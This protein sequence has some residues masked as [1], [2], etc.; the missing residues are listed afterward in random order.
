VA[1]R[2][3]L[4]AVSRS[5]FYAAGPA[6]S[7]GIQAKLTVGSA[8][9]PLEHEADAVADS[10]VGGRTAPAI[11]ALSSSS[12]QQAPVQRA[13]QEAPGP[14]LE[15]ELSPDEVSNDPQLVQSAPALQEAP[16]A[17]QEEELPLQRAPQ[18]VPVAEPDEELPV[19][20]CSC[21]GACTCGAAKTKDGA[22]TEPTHVQ[23]LAISS[24]TSTP[25]GTTSVARAV[26]SPGVG[27]PLQPG[28]RASI[29]RGT[30]HAMSAVRVHDDAAS[31]DAA[32][33]LRARAFTHGS[34]IWLGRSESPADL[35]L[36]SHE[37]TH[38]VQ[39]ADRPA[40]RVGPGR[41]PGA[42]LIQRSAA[43]SS[44]GGVPR[45]LLYL[46]FDNTL[47]VHFLTLDADVGAAFDADPDLAQR[48]DTE[49]TRIFNPAQRPLH[50][51]DGYM[52][53][54]AVGQLI[55][56]GLRALV[57]T[58]NYDFSALEQLLQQR[59]ALFYE[60][61]LLVPASSYLAG[62]LGVA[63][64]AIDWNMLI[65]LL[66]ARAN[67]SEVRTLYEAA[68]RDRYVLFLDMLAS[69]AAALAPVVGAASISA[70]QADAQL[71]TY[72]QDNG[73]G[74]F[75][76]AVFG[77]HS[78]KF[79]D[80]YVPLLE[81]LRYT[82]ATFDL[83]TFRPA[84]DT[85]RLDASREQ[86]VTNFIE[87][88][89]HG[90]VIQFTLDRWTESGQSPEEFLADLD[91]EEFRTELTAQLANELVERARA[92]PELMAALRSR[93]LDQA[94]FVQ[95]S[96]LYFYA[97]GL[98]SYNQGLGATFADTPLDAVSV[99]DAAIAADPYAYYNLSSTIAD[100]L[101]NLLASI[102]PNSPI[103]AA[104]V[105][106]GAT[107]LADQN[108]PTQ[109]AGLFLL[110]ELLAYFNA[111]AKGIEEQERATQE[112]LKD[113]LDLDFAAIADTVRRWSDY[114]D[115][116]IEEVWKPMLKLVALE[117]LAANREEI[118][119]IYDDLDD[120]DAEFILRLNEGADELERLAQRLEAGDYASLELEGQTVTIDDVAELRTA[121]QFLRD[122]AGARS[123]PERIEAQRE[124]LGEALDVYET[125]R[126]DI[127]DDEYDPLD[128]S[129]P[130]YEEARRRLGI[131]EF[132]EFTTVG[133]VLRGDVAATRNPFLAQA[134]VGWHWREGVER[135]IETGLLL[136]GLL[137]LTAGAMLVPG[138]GGAVL[139]ALD[140]GIGIGMGV[141]QIADAN[142]V[143]NMARLDTSGSIRGVSVEAAAH[144]LRQ[145]WIGLGVTVVLTAGPIALSRALRVRGGGGIELPPAVRQ[146]E[147]ALSSETRA[148]LRENPRLRRTFAEMS[149][150]ARRLLT[151]CSRICIPPGT[152]NADAARI[153]TI[154]QRMERDAHGGGY[155]R[156]DE[157]MLREYFFARQDNLGGAIGDIERAANLAHLR[158]LL[159][160]RAS[161]RALAVTPAT[162]AGAAS[163]YPGRWGNVSL[164]D[165]GHSVGEHGATTGADTLAGR[166][167]DPTRVAE[168]RARG[169]TNDVGQWYDNS[170]IVEA[171][172][173]ADATTIINTLADGRTIHRVDMGRPV[174]RI[175]LENGAI[176]SDVTIALV[177]RLP[178]GRLRTAYPIR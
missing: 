13:P 107:L 22:P 122:E 24:A 168:A 67:A 108:I 116:F 26:Q 123:D 17:P 160:E 158:K 144:A 18:E 6:L 165:Y 41:A 132:P 156:A 72:V 86:I 154:V 175:F 81:A 141:H 83:E 40:G 142:E 68:E 19:Q 152:T 100:T 61:D 80:E 149:P 119:L 58:G 159:R 1:G 59:T 62:Q 148:L 153:E 87:T 32:H 177:V 54:T 145:A 155:Q 124:Q 27:E 112:A 73:S 35:H 79:L 2:E 150:T 56:R 29:E 46:P 103:E 75:S 134:I 164:N 34:H 117:W 133:M 176:Q 45:L 139:G 147:D 90:R 15:E 91:L 78:E 5:G 44:R 101:R 82:P 140:V 104:V 36:M 161:A 93:A 84:T 127:E 131:S 126:A 118:Q 9:G 49:L 66:Q 39:Q 31:H 170:L 174:G 30:G 63:S 4:S 37:A 136:G 10:V 135:Q 111:F 52:A 98:Q 43:Y 172:R 163:G 96:W 128:Y 85:A 12:D 25:G 121:A 8:G 21:T 71:T 70:E 50:E 109:F 97:L 48:V 51:T 74:L 113:R 33:A 146:W 178:N 115:T 14:E 102:S 77:Y 138:V 64:A 106:A 125:V 151:H 137:I 169:T 16:A 105:R 130:V 167:T 53:G 69:E 162:S 114:A 157:W 129:R 3:P 88:E 55:E 28:V 11:S 110:P 92:D 95:I 57:T 42:G 60:Q 89:A 65:P 94:R 120:A 38:T 99:E 171:E 20:R 166:A 7:L 76:E 143:L 23:R 47:A 173:R